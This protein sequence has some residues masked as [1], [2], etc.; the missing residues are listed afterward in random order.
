MDSKSLGLCPQGFE[1]PRCRP[2]HQVGFRRVCHPMCNASA[3]NRTRVTSMATMYSTTRPL[4]LLTNI[5]RLLRCCAIHYAATSNKRNK[6]LPRGLEPRTLR[7][8]AVRSD[9]LSYKSLRAQ[10]LSACEK[11]TPPGG[12]VELQKKWRTWASIPVPLAC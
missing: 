4:M 12:T 1:S 2:R 10:G 5:V 6:M 11:R 7:L 9:Q 8:L 3:G